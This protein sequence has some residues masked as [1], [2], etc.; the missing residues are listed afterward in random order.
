MSSP[1]ITPKPATIAGAVTNTQGKTSPVVAALAGR[2]R[3]TSNLQSPWMRL[4]LH[5]M[6]DSGKTTAAAKFMAPESTRIICTRGEDQ[7]ISLRDL[8]YTYI[9]VRD[10]NEFQNAAIYCDQLWPD[11]AKLPER[12]LI[13]D[14]ITR[15][16]DMLV[17]S[18]DAKDNRLI[19]R[20]AT[21]DMA[22]VFSALMK[23]PM[24]I[25]LVALTKVEPKKEMREELIRPD[26]PPAMNNILSADSSYIFYIDKR[27]PRDRCLLTSEKVEA[28]QHYNEQ[29][30]A[31]ETWKRY[32]S[33]RHKI[34]LA[35]A[36][37]KVLAQYE[38]LDLAAVWAKIVAAKG[39]K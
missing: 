12:H 9:E 23:K 26:I 30:K 4:L 11:W 37:A 7:L 33:A 25:T 27:Q 6:I 8:G 29:T 2:T 15:A 28:F 32:T 34:A 35:D 10:A 16:K 3:N 24:H 36:Q 22:M 14:D 5:G 38:P 1:T 31:M 13:I 17:E 20:G 19:Y 21:E 39:A 18:Q